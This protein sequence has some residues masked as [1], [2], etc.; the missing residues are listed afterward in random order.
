MSPCMV[1]ALSKSRGS[2]AVCVAVSTDGITFHKPDLGLSSFNGSSHN[3][4]VFPHDDRADGSK[5]GC[6]D[7]PGPGCRQWWS[8]GAVF[9]DDHA[10]AA[11]RYKMTGGWCPENAAHPCLGTWLF[12][13][14]D[15]LY[16]TNISTKPIC[17]YHLHPR[18]LSPNS[19]LLTVRCCRPR[20]RYS[21]CRAMGPESF[22]ICSIPSITSSRHRR[23]QVRSGSIQPLLRA[24]SP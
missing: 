3:N 6:N 12:S 10:P 2:S 5:R 1:P 16:F 15:G 4:I 13:S 19:H 11:Q 20:Q 9:V 14:P 22:R 21:R 7:K 24:L 23:P 18:H 17:E 8:S